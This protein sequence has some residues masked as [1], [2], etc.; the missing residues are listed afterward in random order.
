MLEDQLAIAREISGDHRRQ[1]VGDGTL[2]LELQHLAAASD[3]AYL[4]LL[5]GLSAGAARRP[6]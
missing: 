2:R 5:A 6:C 1:L 3:T 4:T